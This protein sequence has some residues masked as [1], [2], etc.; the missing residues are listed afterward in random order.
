[1]S[2]RKSLALLQWGNVHKPQLAFISSGGIIRIGTSIAYAVLTVVIARFYGEGISGLMIGLFNIYQALVTDPLAGGLTDRIGSKTVVAMGA[3]LVGI[4]GALWLVLP[5]NNLW[6]LTLFA[7][8]LFTGYSFRD[9]V[10]T[11]LLRT[12]GRTEGGTIFGVAENV[13]AIATFLA[14]ISL[15][16]FLATDHY[17]IAAGV[18]IGTA[19]LAFGLVIGLPDDR[20]A[21]ANKKIA[22]YNP[23]VVV[24][25][26]W[27]FVKVNRYFPLLPLANSV[28]E[29]IF[30]GTVWLIMPL[31]IASG[32]GGIL[33]GLTL[34]IYELVTIFAAAYAGYLADRYN[35]VKINTI[36]W[37][38]AAVGSIMLLF[39]TKVLWLVIIGAVIAIGNNLFAFA[40]SHALEEN[41]IDHEEDGAFIGINNLV[42]DLGYGIAPL[43]IGVIYSFYGFSASLGLAVVVTCTLALVVVPFARRL[44]LRQQK[45]R[46]LS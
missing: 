9:E 14:T 36:G 20:G 29:G 27:H 15:P 38:L 37:A 28:F 18:M 1:M 3:I 30:Y 10:Y 21:L 26:G 39:S 32:E 45:P 42:T 24:K 19:V 12:S 8:F 31:K 33:A 44:R 25:A 13:F 11:Y 41:D 4:A 17:S 16:F 2:I 7:F 40:A 46:P 34:G 35:W 43:I 22:F 6:L 5:F 23:L